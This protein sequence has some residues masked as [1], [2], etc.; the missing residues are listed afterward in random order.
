M[1]EFGEISTGLGFIFWL[2]IKLPGFG[3]ALVEEVWSNVGKALLP[4]EMKTI[5][6][7]RCGKWII[8]ICEK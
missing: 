5:L 6:M 4:C 1:N 3:L 7:G 2:A 8:V